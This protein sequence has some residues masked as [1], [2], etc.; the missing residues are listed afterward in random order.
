M[1]RSMWRSIWDIVSLA[2]ALLLEGG[3]FFLCLFQGATVLFLELTDQL[4]AFAINAGKVVIRLQR[5]VNH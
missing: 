5:S 3:N 1:L 4:I 2:A